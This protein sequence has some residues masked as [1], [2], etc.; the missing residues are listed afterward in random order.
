MW[1]PP[2]YWSKVS[3]Q[4]PASYIIYKDDLGY[5]CAKNGETGKIDYR[6]TDAATVIQSAIDALTEG[7]KILIKKGIYQLTDRL[8]PPNNSVIVGEGW[9]TVLEYTQDLL[10]KHQIG[11]PVGAFVLIN[12]ENVVIANLQ[13]DGKAD[14]LTYNQENC[15]AIQLYPASNCLISQLYIHHIPR[16]GIVL[17]GVG[18]SKNWVL[19]NRIEHVGSTGIFIAGGADE[20]VIGNVVIEAGYNNL[21]PDYDGLFTQASGTENVTNLVVAY[22]TFRNCHRHGMRVRSTKH[23]IFA[24]NVCEGNTS[25]GADFEGTGTESGALEGIIEIGGVYRNN[26]NHGI[27]IAWEVR[28]CYFAPDTVSDNGDYGIYV[29]VNSEA[30]YQPHNLI[31]APKVVSNNGKAGIRLDGIDG[32]GYVSD[33]YIYPGVIKDNGSTG[34]HPYGIILNGARHIIIIGGIIRNEVTSYQAYG[35]EERSPSDYNLIL[36]SDCRNNNLGAI[37]LIATNSKAITCPGYVTENSG[38]ATIP[39]GSTSVTVNHGLASKPGKVLVTPLSDPGAYWYVVNITDTSFDIV[40][41][42]APTSDVTFAW[43]AEV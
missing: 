31:I 18:R 33:I 26:S 42:A 41:S 3:P 43:Q 4:Q 29:A 40:L 23:S 19:F 14:T 30:V 37:H 21:G 11:Y 6:D 24:F 28:D 32:V 34:T 9:G 2:S 5:V 12:K 27:T 25:Y 1:K 35:I 36:F 39:A 13:I 8:E 17:S 22:N 7:G 38:T 15:G 16:D 20:K 10:S